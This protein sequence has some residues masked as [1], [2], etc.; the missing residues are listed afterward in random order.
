MPT[1]C[2][3]IWFRGYLLRL[4]P[5]W[6]SVVARRAPRTKP[7][8]R[9]TT[10]ASARSQSSS[11][12]EPHRGTS[13]DPRWLISTFPSNKVCPPTSRNLPSW[14][15]RLLPGIEGNLLMLVRLVLRLVALGGLLVV[16]TRNWLLTTRVLGVAT[17]KFLLGWL[18]CK[19]G[20]RTWP[21]VA[22]SCDKI[23]PIT[24]PMSGLAMEEKLASVMGVPW[25]S[26]AARSIIS[27]RDDVGCRFLGS[28][29]CSTGNT[30]W[31]PTFCMGTRESARALANVHNTADIF[32]VICAHWCRSSEIVAI[33]SDQ[34]K[35]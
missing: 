20:W 17:T 12:M 24:C 26:A 10:L 23:S 28:C 16:L 21:A 7:I 18:N 35:F 32:P 19:I 3:F 6:L 27:E 29:W 25:L 31:E 8:S 22:F 14:L 13:P 5:K 9:Q 34:W 15:F 1:Y 11:Q 30:C 4:F 33:L 2:F